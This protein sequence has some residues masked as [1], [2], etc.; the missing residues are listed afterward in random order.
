MSW[1]RSC[2]PPYSLSPQRLRTILLAVV[3]TTVLLI[4]VVGRLADDVEGSLVLE[5]GRGV[6]ALLR[7]IAQ[8]AYTDTA[9]VANAEVL[10]VLLTGGRHREIED[11]QT[12]E[13]HLIAFEEQFHDAADELL[14]DALHLGGGEDGAVLLD[15]TAQVAGVYD[16]SGLK[17][18]VGT[19]VCLG[20]RVVVHVGFQ[21]EFC[22]NCKC[23][24]CWFILFV[25]RSTSCNAKVRPFC[26][27][28]SVICRLRHIVPFKELNIRKSV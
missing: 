10:G 17:A 27:A 15:V 18:G 11:A 22:H 5:H 14:G 12:V 28:V 1:E 23:L 24:E 21:I 7:A 8:E 9:H 2:R 4:V 13:F 26:L 19:A 3:V 16:L 25:V 20:L 6:F